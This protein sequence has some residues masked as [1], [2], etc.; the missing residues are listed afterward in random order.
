MG[1]GDAAAT[2]Q[3]TANL[4]AANAGGDFNASASL[5]TGLNFERRLRS[6]K[7]SGPDIDVVMSPNFLF[8]SGASNAANQDRPIPSPGPKQ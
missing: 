7:F 8:L 5:F 2:A 1:C 3:G 6:S 4:N